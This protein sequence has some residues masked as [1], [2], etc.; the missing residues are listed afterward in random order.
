MIITS[1]RKLFNT[2]FITLSSLSVIP[3]FPL[4]S[5][6]FSKEPRNANL[7]CYVL[8]IFLK[9]SMSFTDDPYC[10]FIS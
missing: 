4:V 3:E 2:S 6:A 5:N 8:Y 10:G 9:V 7:P 1:S